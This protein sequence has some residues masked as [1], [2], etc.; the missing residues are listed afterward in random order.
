MIDKAFQGKNFG[1][2]LLMDAQAR[3]DEV[4][5]KV[6]I[7][8]MVLDAR[9][10]KLASWYEKYDFIRFPAQLRMFK[11]IALIRKMNLLDTI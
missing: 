2:L 3:V 5:S 4:S 10:E 11:T 7:R 9:N 1:E 6:G 8:A